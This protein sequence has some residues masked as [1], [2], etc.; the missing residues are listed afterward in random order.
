MQVS[1]RGNVGDA[2]DGGVEDGVAGVGDGV[3]GP[4]GADDGIGVNVDGGGEIGAPSHVARSSV[5][6]GPTGSI[7]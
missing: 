7:I 4:M 2:G 3:D 5:A 6:P 1:D